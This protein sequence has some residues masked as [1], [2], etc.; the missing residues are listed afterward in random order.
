M[1]PDTKVA[2]QSEEDQSPETTEV[3]E[4]DKTTTA[5]KTD[6]GNQSAKSSAKSDKK[7][8]DPGKVRGE[9]LEV[10]IS[11]IAHYNNPRNEP[12]NLFNM[13]FVLLGDP[14]IEECDSE[15]TDSSRFVSLVHMALDKD[16]AGQYVDLID[17]HESVDRKEEPMADQSIVELAKDITECGQL[18]PILVRKDRN[19]Y[20]G[21][22]GGR[23]IAAIL[24]LHAKSVVMRAEKHADAPKKVYPA[25]VLVTTDPCKQGEVF[26]HSM[27][28]NL[29]R[30][31]FSPLQQGRVYH[32]MLQQINPKTK[33]KW[34]MKDAAA[35]LKIEY[36][37]FRN[38]EALWRPYDSDTGR[39]LTDNQRQRVQSGEL[40]VTAAAR[41]ALGEKHYSET[42]KPSGKRKIGLPLKE[43]QK[44]FDE[45]AEANVE[46]R[47]AIAEC[48]GIAITKAA[49]E[50]D[51]RISEAD[52]REMN[53][54]E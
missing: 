22:D 3:P 10:P 2:S 5:S 34:T 13:G 48:M 9:V 54:T 17:E 23:R 38:R 52:N 30:K 20:I 47:T 6:T 25:T 8:F 46:R 49:S 21:I 14:S 19:S 1:S 33:K 29:S 11:S 37:T 15:E 50:S 39:G 18:V 27:V 43:M 7:K 51:A 45:S 42:G 40:G 31:D 28:A 16:Y 53:R 35:E 32:Q 36:G 24:Y 12:E 4:D 26:L 44:L 41:K